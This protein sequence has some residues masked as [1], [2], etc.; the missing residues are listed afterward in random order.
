MGLRDQT[1]RLNGI[2][3]FNNSYFAGPMVGKK[4]E[5]C[6]KARVFVALTLDMKGNSRYLKMRVTPSIKREIIRKLAQSSFAEGYTVP[7]D[8]YRN[9]P[10]SGLLHWL[11]IIISNAKAFILG[12]YHDLPKK[13]FQSYLNEYS[14]HFSRRNFGRAFDLSYRYICSDKLKE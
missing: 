1:H 2:V 7:S 5:C 11:H 8:D 12:I 4:R 13:N 10:N 3:E 9:D 14:F 6:T